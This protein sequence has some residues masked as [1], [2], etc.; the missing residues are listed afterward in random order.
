MSDSGVAPFG[1]AFGLYTLHD[2]DATE[3]FSSCE[4]NDFLE[5][6]IGEDCGHETEL[7]HSLW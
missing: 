1:F 5:G 7:Q 4:G 3:L 2:L 6:Q